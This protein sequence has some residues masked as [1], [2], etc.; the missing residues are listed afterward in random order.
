MKALG[1]NARRLTNVV[2]AQAIWT[3]GA[4]LALAIALTVA[5]AWA[6]GRFTGNLSVAVEPSAVVRVAVGGLLLAALGA[7]APL[8]KVWRVDPVTVFRR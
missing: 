3:V 1:A 4:A 5:L 2:L 6:L 8:I 7:V